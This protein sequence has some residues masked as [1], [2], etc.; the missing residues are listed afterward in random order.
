MGYIQSSLIRATSILMILGTLLFAN[1]C[2]DNAQVAQMITPTPTPLASPTPTPAPSPTPTPA[3]VFT[4][5][6]LRIG[7]AP[8]NRVIGFEVTVGPNPLVVTLTTGQSVNLAVQHNRWELSHMAGKMEP[9][10]IQSFP[11]GSVTSIQIPLTDP[12]VTYLDDLGAVHTFSGTPSQTVTVNLSPPLT[13]GSTPAIVTLDINVASTLTFDP[14]GAVTAITFSSSTFT[15]GTKSIAAEAEQQDD[16]GEI[17]GVTGKVTLVNS[18]SFVLDAGQGG[19]AI[20]FVTDAT[21]RLENAVSFAS[22]LNQIVKVEGFT[23]VDGS[24]FAKVVEKVASDSGSELEGVIIDEDGPPL[25]SNPPSIKVLVQDGNGN[26][27]DPGKIGQSFLVAIDSSKFSNYTIDWGK[28]VNVGGSF[29]GREISP[30]QRVE[31]ELPGGVPAPGAMT[32]V[33]VEIKLEQQAING[34]VQNFTKG[35]SG[36]AEFDLKLPADSFITLLTKVTSIHVFVKPETD[37][38][39]PAIA[40][41]D[42]VRVRGLLFF[43]LTADPANLGPKPWGIFGMI[44]R[45]IT[46][47]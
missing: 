40:N 16:N 6:Q 5:A 30:G 13:I 12:E 7:D 25:S 22:L 11:E 1:G 47:P 20:T 21:T 28:I 2:G 35:T 31:V 10:S 41:T 23:Q 9:L 26:G 33:P 24:V 3:P 19:A 42:N 15:F 39:V 44:A 4:T 46:A 17:E 36:T 32:D 38:K 29:N 18:S 34:Q 27:M 37:M 43:H 45:R 14:A 8:A